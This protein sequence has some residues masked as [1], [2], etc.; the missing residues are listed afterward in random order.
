[1]K[2]IPKWKC[3]EKQLLN[4]GESFDVLR[5][6]IDSEVLTTL[7]K[8]IRSFPRLNVKDAYA[9]GQLHSKKWLVT[10]LEKI[11]MHL[12]T[13]FLCAGWY[14]TLATMLFESKRYI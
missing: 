8:T 14:G 3:L 10:E 9:R 6:F 2:T 11:G 13:V 12:G 1:M 4:K 7:P 5:L